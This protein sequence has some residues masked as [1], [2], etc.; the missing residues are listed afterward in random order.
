MRKLRRKLDMSEV[1]INRIKSGNYYYVRNEL[2][3]VIKNNCIVW[4]RPQ[5]KQTF[6]DKV[7][8][9]CKPSLY[10]T[11]NQLLTEELALYK[12]NNFK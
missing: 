1:L 3:A 5:Y 11:L 6:I 4:Y 12:R 9:T 10:K 8:G 7:K 2:A